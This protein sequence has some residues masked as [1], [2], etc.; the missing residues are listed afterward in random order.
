MEQSSV[1][2]YDSH[3]VDLRVVISSKPWCSFPYTEN[4]TP[5]YKEWASQF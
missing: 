5:K 2:R 3:S 4:I 1:E